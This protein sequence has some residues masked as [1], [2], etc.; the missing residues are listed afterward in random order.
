MPAQT[1]STPDTKP[2]QKKLTPQEQQLAAVAGGNR[3]DLSV[4]VAPDKAEFLPGEDVGITI[5]VTNQGEALAKNIRFGHES[6]RAWLA[7]GADELSARPSLA[8]GQQ[9]VFRVVLQPKSHTDAE[10]P[11]LFR[12]T[13]DG[14]ADPTPGDNGTNLSIKVRQ[15]KG[16]ASGVVYLDKDG[17]GRFDDG[18]GLANTWVTV[19]G[20]LP[21][22]AKH[23]F[24]NA[25][26]EFRF[27]SLPAGRYSAVNLDSSAH[28][29]VV[30]PGH[31][32]F[33]VELGQDTRLGLPVVAP[34]SATLTA[35]MS[36]DK[37]SYT[38]AEEV[39][40]NVTLKNTGSAPL[41]RIVAICNTADGFVPGTGDGWRELAPGGEGV[42][43]APG[44]TKIVRVTDR[45]P[46][47]VS[48]KTFY[49]SCSFGNNGTV[50]DGYV[51]G[52]TAYASVVGEFGTVDIYLVNGQGEP[53]RGAVVGVL[54][55]ATRRPLKDVTTDYHGSA[56]IYDVPA[57]KIVLVVA[58]KWKPKDG[59]EFTLDVVPDMWNSTM[60]RVEPGDVEVP[61]VGKN[62]P[63]FEVTAKFD[64]E[65][66]D[67]A[68][69]M[70]VDVTVKNVGTGSDHT[71]WL[72]TPYISEPKL[73]FDWRQ[74][75]ELHYD[76]K[77]R[78]WPGESRQITIVGR[79]PDFID[80]GKVHLK[81]DAR[82]DLDVNSA[83]NSVLVSAPVTFLDGDAAV[84]VYADRNGNKQRDSGEDLPNVNVLVSGG[85]RPYDAQQGKT[86]ASG[87]VSF[88]GLPVG[89][90]KVW[91]WGG[92]EGWVRNELDQLTV[93]AGTESVLEIGTVRP[94]SDKLFASVRFLKREY[95][96]G[97]NYELDVT[98]ENRTGADMP[99][100][101]ALCY[102]AGAAGEIHNDGSGW[103]ALAYG[104]PGVPLKNGE[105]RTWRVS[106]PQ[107]AESASL[108]YATIGCL[109]APSTSD[110]G[111][112]PASDGFR[113]PG[114]Y[115][116]AIGKLVQDNENNPIAGATIALVDHMSQKTVTRTITDEAGLFK[117]FNLPV[118]RYD[119]VLEGPWKVDYRRLHN[120]FFHVKVGEETKVQLLFR[121]P[122]PETEEPGYPLPEDQQPGVNT[123][124][125]PAGAG[126]TGD[127]L[128]KTGASVVGL[129][130]LGALLVAFGLG[131]SVI[132]RRRAA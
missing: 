6:A 24:T 38:R 55:A 124:P 132:G 36:F 3:A 19:V 89:V 103:G 42:T 69:P 121:V 80:G 114:Q 39:G 105:K 29:Y 8:P 127:A 67:I 78:L 115:A 70:R 41:T 23:E 35:S 30:Q 28:N 125:A 46:A 16:S 123:P 129:G 117:V 45:V 33:V 57:G 100:V 74:L 59:K 77:V 107:P 50:T 7:A 31:N 65:S 98:L 92:D 43:L 44:E 9:K 13:L 54:D 126:G 122:G 32:D 49:A 102:V 26:G 4:R 61:E 40:L 131:A 20:G 76:H 130:V 11:F 72:E 14:I 83:N 106:G 1:P 128:A 119:L 47:K 99:S 87:R 84:V 85:T 34:A 116:D 109:F 94:L 2:E 111:A 108:G 56:L 97:E 63:D 71:V 120:Q 81:L 110:R 95:A 79:A 5:T 62:R 17:N 96:P 66:Y 101:K 27:A 113:V 18:E 58:G 22:D 64:K 51:S 15:D 52:G 91:I 82:S 25:K 12:A 60:L 48:F 21:R 104:G 37:P 53:V 93:S 88:R 112:A 73:E 68:E 118:G 86:D 90:F 10:V 75:G